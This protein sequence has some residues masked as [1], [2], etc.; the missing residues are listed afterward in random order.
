[1]KNKTIIVVYTDRKLGKKDAAKLKRYAFNTTA[2]V[3]EG[4]MLKSAEYSTAMQV[5]K[6]LPKAHKY[7]NASTGELSDTYNST[8]QWEIRDFIVRNDSETAVYGSILPNE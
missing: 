8:A 2:S 7:F 3:K 6:I 5:V 4:V 1:M